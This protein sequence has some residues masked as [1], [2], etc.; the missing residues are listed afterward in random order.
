MLTIGIVVFVSTLV[1]IAVSPISVSVD[2]L[3]QPDAGQ[4]AARIASISSHLPI[5]DR[6][7]TPNSRASKLAS[8][9]TTKQEQTAKRNIRVA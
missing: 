7:G 6:P 8:M 3:G 1:W 4:R 2:A 9:G 5:F